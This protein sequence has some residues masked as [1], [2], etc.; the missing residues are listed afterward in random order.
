[1]AQAKKPAAKKT[2][3]KPKRVAP[4]ARQKAQPQAPKPQADPSVPVIDAGDSAAAA[5][6]MVANKVAP[7]ASSQPAGTESALF[8]HLKESLNKPHSQIMGGLLDKIGP[9][10]QKK[11]A[12]PFD[13]TKQV[14][15]DQTYGSDATRRNV[16]RRTAG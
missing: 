14:S 16:P 11:S 5:A 13:S 6:A 2:A 10:G 15:H 3:G 4:P 1:M 12:A 7:T 8:R 9:A